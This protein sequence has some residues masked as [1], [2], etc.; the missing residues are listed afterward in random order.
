VRDRLVII[1][2]YNEEPLIGQVLERVLASGPWDI[3]VVEDGSTDGTF[4]KVSSRRGVGVLR[5]SG[6]LGY[7]RS[8][9]DG[10]RHAVARG[11]RLAATIDGDQQH[12]PELLPRFFGEA[13]EADIVSGSRYLQES[14]VK[15]DAPHERK[16]LNAVITDY[17]RTLTGFAITD[18]FCGYKAYRVEKLKSLRLSEEGYGL[19][20]QVWIQAWAHGLTVREL[21]VSLIYLEGRNNF[22]PELEDP[23]A[24]YRYYMDVIKREFTRCLTFLP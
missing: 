11:Y 18:A 20:L 17:L 24:R 19:P 7:G 12:E 9:I 21:P 14:P 15:A 13:E 1:P 4:E 23:V 2:A 5:H 8:L 16:S 3:L 10:F 6:R 22:I